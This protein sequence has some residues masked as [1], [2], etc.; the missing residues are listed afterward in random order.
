MDKKK[1]QQVFENYISVSLREHEIWCLR[2]K[3]ETPEAAELEVEGL[4]L[5]LSG[6]KAALS[7][8]DF[9]E[10]EEEGASFIKKY[11]SY[12][13]I[14]PNDEVY[15]I[16][17]REYVKAQGYCLQVAIKRML[18]IYFDEKICEWMPDHLSEIE[19]I[20]A[21]LFQFS[22][23]IAPPGRPSKNWGIILKELDRRDKAGELSN[24]CR[25]SISRELSAWYN[26]REVEK[27]EPET[28][29]KK[30]KDSFDKLGISPTG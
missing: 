6:Y 28:V 8:N 3:P 19:G 18:G 23:T 11:F 10:F 24:K 12:L 7:M 26:A 27:I 13:H 17:L 1:I 15:R 29:R 22:S 20:K 16:L 4:E 14:Q 5:H 30:L 9:C 21:D 2:Y 25:A